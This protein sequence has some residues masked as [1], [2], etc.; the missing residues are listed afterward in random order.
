MSAD[1]ACNLQ[2]VGSYPKLMAGVDVSLIGKDEAR[3]KEIAEE[4]TFAVFSTSVCAF[5]PEALTLD[6]T[7]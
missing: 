7:Q 6:V 4:G 5:C 1:F 3:L 2:R